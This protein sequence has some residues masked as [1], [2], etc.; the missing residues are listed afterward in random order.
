[1][2]SLMLALA[3]RVSIG[4]SSD[5]G[6]RPRAVEHQL[7][8]AHRRAARGGWQY[9]VAVIGE[10]EG[11]DQLRLAARKLGD[12][13]HMQPVFAQFVEQVGDTPVRLG[14]GKFVLDQP[15]R[16]LL[17]DLGE[18]GAPFAVGG[19]VLGKRHGEFQRK[20]KFYSTTKLVFLD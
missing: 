2:Y 10:E 7:G 5:R 19:K 12:K 11:I 17:Q 6:P 20:D 9:A 1:L 13:G 18:V 14:V 3:S 8:R 16:E 4:S 15:E